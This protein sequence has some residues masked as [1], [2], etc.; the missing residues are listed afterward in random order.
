[1]KPVPVTVT[2]VPAGPLVGL[3]VIDDVVTVKVAVGELVPS[4]AKTVWDPAVEDGTVKVAENE[5]ED[6][7]VTVVGLV[8][9]VV[10]SYFIV[11]V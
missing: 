3:R 11:M 1:M 8:V 5:P 10:P 6:E 2:V 9:I 4:V 7:V